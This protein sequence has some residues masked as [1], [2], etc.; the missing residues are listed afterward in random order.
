MLRVKAIRDVMPNTL[1]PNRIGDAADVVHFGHVVN[2]EDV[3]SMGDRPTASRRCSPN[4]LLGVR[5]VEDF[6]DKALARWPDQERIAQ[7]S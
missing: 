5:L 1:A 4:P 3:G 2:T 7:G 6:A